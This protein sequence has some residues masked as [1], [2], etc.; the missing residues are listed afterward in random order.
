MCGLSALFT[1]WFLIFPPQVVP[2][3]TLGTG[4]SVPTAV[5]MLIILGALA[6][7]VQKMGRPAAIIGL[8]ICASGALSNLQNVQR[9]SATLDAY[10]ASYRQYEG[11]VQQYPQ[12]AQQQN[13]LVQQYQQASSAYY[14]SWFMLLIS[15]ISVGAFTNATRGTLAYRRM[16]AAHAT[17]DKQDALTAEDLTA[18]KGTIA[19]WFGKS[20][21]ATAP[22][23]VASAPIAQPAAV[24]QRTQPVST[25]AAPAQPGPIPVPPLAV[26]PPL[27]PAP[28]PEARTPT[29]AVLVAPVVAAETVRQSF[30]AMIGVSGGLIY[31]PRV[32]AFLAANVTAGL[33]FVL[34]RTVTAS[35]SVSA[36]YWLWAI[37]AACVFTAATVVGFRF[38]A[39]A[40]A[41]M[42]ASAG[43][44]T[45]ATLPF[46][47]MLPSFAWADI[48]FREQ[49]QQFILLPLISSFILLAALS[50]VVPRLQPMVLAL[51]L[52]AMGT[53]IATSVVLNLLHVLGA[54]EP[55]D[56]VLGGASVISAVLRSLAFALVL[57]GG[58]EYLRKQAAKA[59]AG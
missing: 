53:E 22:A 52:A 16:V 8:V 35:V 40:W 41:A 58:L 29:E 18:I 23:A 51:W 33:I 10:S 1:V 7:G 20:R 9:A 13:P 12:M 6:W 36:A 15:L 55:P 3:S 47:A 25:Q 46:Y 24:P 19:G 27:S 43:I 44:A 11:Y 5:T 39:N 54:G 26:A 57:W 4:L 31:W 45:L 21:R 38:V 59:T 28:V 32:L 34:S 50:W 56:A 14:G 2:G 48:G 49:F 37:C 42:A 30:A 17:P